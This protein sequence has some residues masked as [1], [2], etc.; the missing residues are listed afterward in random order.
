MASIVCISGATS[1]LGIRPG[2]ILVLSE[3]SGGPYRMAP[4]RLNHRRGARS[5]VHDDPVALQ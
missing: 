4:G 1:C 3:T 5:L 2:Q